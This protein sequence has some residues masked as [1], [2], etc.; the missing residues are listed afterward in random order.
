MP[1]IRY[2]VLKKKQTLQCFREG[3]LIASYTNVIED[4]KVEINES[5]IR[6]NIVIS[7]NPIVI[8]NC[9]TFKIKEDL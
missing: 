3:W 6:Y 9:D 5:L 7:A 4:V 1:T 8:I 2:T